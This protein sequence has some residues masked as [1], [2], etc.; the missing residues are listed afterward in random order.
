MLLPTLDFSPKG[1]KAARTHFL[2]AAADLA[3]SGLLRQTGV[4]VKV[5]SCLSSAML[6]EG[7]GVGASDRAVSVGVRATS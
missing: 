2:Q 5:V 4:D 7:S 3:K 1:N 6:P